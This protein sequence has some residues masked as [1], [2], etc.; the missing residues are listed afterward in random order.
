MEFIDYNIVDNKVIFNI[1]INKYMSNQPKTDEECIL[2][3]L[4][5][6]ALSEKIKIEYSEFKQIL[7]FDCIDSHISQLENIK[8]VYYIIKELHKFTKDDRLLDK[9]IIKNYGLN[10]YKF[11]Q[12]SKY[13]LPDYITSLIEFQD[14]IV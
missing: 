1:Y 12:K 14:E 13:V 5:I 8:Y 4:S 2:I 6:I 3:T 10:F 11:Y 9:I 7:I